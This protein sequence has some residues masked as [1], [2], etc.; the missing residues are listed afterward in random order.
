MEVKRQ[1]ANT[2][3]APFR[4]VPS[5][6]NASVK[7]VSGSL[8]LVSSRYHATVVALRS[9]VPVAMVS[10]EAKLRSL[11]ETANLRISVLENWRDLANFD[12]LV[13]SGSLDLPGAELASEA[14]RRLINEADSFRS[15]RR[16]G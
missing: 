6:I 5:E 4:I 2:I 11:A 14:I 10:R 9:A 16:A 15:S 3:Q 7:A 1:L 8:L 13:S 12:P